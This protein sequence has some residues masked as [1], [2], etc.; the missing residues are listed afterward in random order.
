M[1]G[2]KKI[3]EIMIQISEYPVVYD[4]DTLK[5]AV[6]ILKNYLDGGKEHRSLLVFS[7]TGKVGGEEELIG[8]LTVRDILNALKRNRTGYDNADLFTMSLASL[9]WAY[10]ETAGKFVNVKVGEVL[11]PLVEAFIRSDDNITTAIELMMNKN[12]NILPVF[13]GKKAVGIIRALDVLDYIV[14]VL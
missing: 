14:E 4:D 2:T 13:D 10:L 9:G 6:K 8:I 12:V 7:R 3:K 5:D 11:R 1:P